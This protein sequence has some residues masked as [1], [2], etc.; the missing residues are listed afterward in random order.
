MSKD[1][2]EFE[3]DLNNYIDELV[4]RYAYDEKIHEDDLDIRVKV[5]PIGDI[6]TFI[7]LLNVD[8]EIG[9]IATMEMDNG[10]TKVVISGYGYDAEGNF[11]TKH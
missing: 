7:L 5:F 3:H 4:E 9:S 2:K 11:T 8:K 10:Q 1:I 6:G